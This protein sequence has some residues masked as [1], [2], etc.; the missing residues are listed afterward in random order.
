MVFFHCHQSPCSTCLQTCE[1]Y[2]NSSTVFADGLH[3][4]RRSQ[5]CPVCGCIIGWQCHVHLFSR[6]LATIEPTMYRR[7]LLSVSRFCL[8]AHDLSQ[9][10]SDVCTLLRAK[11]F[12]IFYKYFFSAYISIFSQP[13]VVEES[14]IKCCCAFY[15]GRLISQTSERQLQ[16]PPPRQSISEMDPKS[17]TKNSLGRFA[18]PCHTSLPKFYRWGI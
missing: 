1:H 11:Y 5:A 6:A 7:H 9:Y 14:L 12:F 4:S 8:S 13:K 16:F 10:I 2:I 18:H 15:H 17:D 3:G